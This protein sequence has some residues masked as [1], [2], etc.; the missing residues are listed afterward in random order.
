LEG[1][2]TKAAEVS[3]NGR[4]FIKGIMSG[5]VYLV[6]MKIKILIPLVNIGISKEDTTR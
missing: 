6:S 4:I 3:L 2:K 5:D 1:D